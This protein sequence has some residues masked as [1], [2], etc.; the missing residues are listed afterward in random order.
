MA[1]IPLILLLL[2]SLQLACHAY[3]PTAS[4]LVGVLLALSS[5]RISCLAAPAASTLG[6]LEPANG[7][8]LMIWPDT[9]VTP[10]QADTPSLINQRLGQRVPVWHFAQNI[11]TLTQSGTPGV[12]VNVGIDTK[13]NTTFLELT[14]SDAM[15]FLTVY[16]F[17]TGDMN[18]VNDTDIAALAT[19]CAQLNAAGR[20][21]FL[22]LAP[23]M[24][25]GWYPWGQKPS[26]YVPWWRKVVTAVRAQ[27]PNTAFVWS[28]N[29]RGQGGFALA[30]WV[31]PLGTD[32]NLMDTNKDGV[33]NGTDDPYGPFYPGD[34]YVDWVGLSLYYYGTSY[35]YHFNTLPPDYWF[36]QSL[37]GFGA[38]DFY[39]TYSVQHNKPFACSECSSTF[40]AAQPVGSSLVNVPPGPGELAIKRSLSKNKDVHRNQK[41]GLFEF[42][43]K[44]DDTFRDFQILNQSNPNNLLPQFLTDLQAASS[45]I[46]FIWANYSPPPVVPAPL[47]ANSTPGDH[48]ATIL[49]MNSGHSSLRTIVQR[50][51]AYFAMFVATWMLS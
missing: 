33:V 22:R 16:P 31:H 24:N 21:I 41:R 19:Q 39:Q 12:S 51:G 43:K 3:I 44:E 35:P 48:I 25:G 50:Y 20:K 1:R 32:Y 11:P 8:Y 46:N 7:V 34:D 27:A 4:T 42:R 10:Y 14:Y 49:G 45:K 18:A 38:F 15:I 26:V 36:V 6:L 37:Q 30:S 9:E 29:V 28:P 47:P 40:F 13:I 5:Y 17:L 23:E 2:S